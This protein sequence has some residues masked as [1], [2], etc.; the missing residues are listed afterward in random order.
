MHNIP[1][2]IELIEKGNPDFVEVKAYSHI[3]DSQSR[4]SRN[5]QPS[6]KE[7][8]DFSIQIAENSAWKFKDEDENSRV[9]LLAKN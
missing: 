3:G 5:H 7:V 8:R 2:W 9:V 6:M 1:G 4:L